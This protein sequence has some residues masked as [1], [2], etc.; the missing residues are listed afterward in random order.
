MK[1][2][3]ACLLIAPS[4]ASAH[5]TSGN[6]LLNDMKGSNINKAV[7]L[8]YVLGVTDAL[9]KVVICPPLNVTAGQVQ[10][11]IR[12]HLEDNPSIRHYSADSIIGNKLVTIWP[13]H[14][15]KDV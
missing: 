6:D 1:N 2:I 11:I 9:N 3:I 8:G 12:K 10:D 5:F 14:K 4:I 15:G 7:A 13:C